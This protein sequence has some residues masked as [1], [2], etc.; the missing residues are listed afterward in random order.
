VHSIHETPIKTNKPIAPLDSSRLTE[1][2]LDAPREQ[3]RG[4]NWAAE[5]RRGERVLVFPPYVLYVLLFVF[6]QDRSRTVKSH[7]NVR[8][9]PNY[10][11]MQRCILFQWGGGLPKTMNRFLLSR[12]DTGD[13]SGSGRKSGGSQGCQ[14]TN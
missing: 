14:V 5:T 10:V 6:Q 4:L 2:I 1:S 13:A 9:Y 12:S 8:Q 3:S 7:M 11:E